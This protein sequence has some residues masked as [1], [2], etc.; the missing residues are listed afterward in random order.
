MM[1]QEAERL[2][3]ETWH[4]EKTGVVEADH[5]NGDPFALGIAVRVGSAG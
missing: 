3:A 1:R 5:G 2:S 4:I